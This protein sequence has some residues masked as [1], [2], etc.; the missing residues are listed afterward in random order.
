MKNFKAFFALTA[1]TILFASCTVISGWQE[2]DEITA[3]SPVSSRAATISLKISGFSPKARTV[4]P[5]QPELSELTNIVLTGKKSGSTSSVTLA[6]AVSWNNLPSQIGIANGTW[7]SFSLELNAGDTKYSGQAAGF[8]VRE[9]DSKTISFNLVESSDVKGHGGIDFT[10]SLPGSTVKSARITL[11]SLDSDS[12]L[13]TENIS[14]SGSEITFKRNKNSTAEY[15]EAGTYRLA[16][17]MYGDALSSQALEL[18]VYRAIVNVAGG[19]TSSGSDSISNLHDIY[20]ISYLEYS[21]SDGSYVNFTP[22]SSSILPEVYTRK[23]L[24]INLPVPVRTGSVFAGWYKDEHFSPDE[25]IINITSGS[26]GDITLYAKW[27]SMTLYASSTG[28][29]SYTG[30]NSKNAVKT[31]QKAVDIIDELSS[32]TDYTLPNQNWTIIVSGLLSGNTTIMGS[33]VTSLTIKGK[34]G[35]GSD[36]LDGNQTDK[37]LDFDVNIPVLIQGLTIQ[38]GKST[39]SGGGISMDGSGSLTLT[40]CIVTENECDFLGA[41]DDTAGGGGIYISSTATLVLNG[42]T[43]VKNNKEIQ[44]NGKGGGIYNAGILYIGY[45]KTASG[46]YTVDSAFT[47]EIASN[48]AVYGG[49]IYNSGTKIFMAGGK[50]TQ[51]T[52]TQDGA[53]IRLGGSGDEFTMTG[54]EIS[55]NSAVR[56]GGAFYIGGP[57]S[58]IISGGTVSGNTGLFGGAVYLKGNLKL[59]AQASL[60]AGTDGEN[61]VYLENTTVSIT[62]AGE[63]TGEEPVATIRPSLATG[64]SDYT[65][66]RQVL[67][68]SAAMLQSEHEKF[69]VTKAGS[70]GANW[71][72]DQ[73]GKLKA[74]RTVYISEMGN[75]SADGFSSERA[76]RTFT[77]ALS[78]IDNSAVEWTVKVSGN[79]TNT[80]TVVI[81]N[82]IQAKTL[83]IE[84]TT[85]TSRDVIIGNGSQT[86]MTLTTNI[87][88]TIKNLCIRG[89]GTAGLSIMSE[90]TDTGSA[91]VKLEGLAI[92]GNSKSGLRISEYSNCDVEIK[93]SLIGG[94]TDSDSNTAT[95]GGGILKEGD[96]TLTIT[97]TRIQNNKSTPAG[98]GYGGGGLY[99]SDGTVILEE[100][101]KF[102][103]NTSVEKGGAV[104]VKDGT[105]ILKDGVTFSGNTSGSSQTTKDDICLAAGTTVSI[106]EN[107]S[108]SQIIAFINPQNY[109]DGTSLL[110][111][112]AVSSNYERFSVTGDKTSIWYIDSTG[113]LRKQP[114][115]T[116][117]PEGNPEDAIEI[118]DPSKSYV[119]NGTG[120][121]CNQITVYATGA[122]DTYYVTL[123][124]IRRNAEAYQSALTFENTYPGTSLTVYLT[125]NGNNLLNAGNHG[126]IKVIGAE[127]AVINVI[128]LTTSTATLQFGATYD[129]I[130]DLQVENVEANFSFADDCTLTYA[131]TNN[132]SHSSAE[133]FFTAAKTCTNGCE[134]TITK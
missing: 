75:D 90:D 36:K 88:V 79:I 131:R 8:T 35:S 49:G 99:I 3:Y 5:S 27:I 66:G 84:G 110:S 129:G 92:T 61:D 15:I 43:S 28:N 65:I 89:G 72:I 121:N 47:G 85:S 134:F 118:K 126:G 30:T 123:N 113:K 107:F 127:G 82:S 132:V 57:S 6:E 119:L 18:N 116:I 74:L 50:I 93:D 91:T 12:P 95:T 102:I 16:I 55:E 45:K 21:E 7:T 37:V 25:K 80:S 115:E 94:D 51:N 1:F 101:T 20:T 106:E 48:S 96:R 73:E 63:L 133:D 124:E 114:V 69:A 10:L 14:V 64:E 60:P 117:S 70:A 40:D 26:T 59:S 105:L 68:G 108:G 2:E 23:S 83:T 33:G 100:G 13:I 77:T 104:F 122:D 31:L 22:A 109:T 19:C 112:T 4:N 17:T 81:P 9:G 87:P 76:V 44:P 58:V 52:V 46:T 78:K 41:A 39:T 98:T 130:P 67:T 103:N 125:I 34:T 56:Y 54:G 32:S 53:G 29:D 86:A 120:T 42:S 38:K 62:V 11:S 128:F 71:L 24:E 111:G 97:N